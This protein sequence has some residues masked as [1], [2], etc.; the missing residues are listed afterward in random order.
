MFKQNKQFVHSVNN[1]YE[2]ENL[3]LSQ[4]VRKYP[5]RGRDM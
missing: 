5:F 3:A 1:Y 4:L 2:L